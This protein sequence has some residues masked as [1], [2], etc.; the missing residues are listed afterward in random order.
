VEAVGAP[1][2][3]YD[4][5][6]IEDDVLL[7]RNNFLVVLKLVL[8]ENVA[9]LGCLSQKGVDQRLLP[10]QSKLFSY[11]YKLLVELAVYG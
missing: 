9:D 11:C 2:E 4:V 1:L 5:E 10:V 6:E 3:G 8:E 7:F